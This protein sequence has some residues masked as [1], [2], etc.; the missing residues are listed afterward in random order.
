MCRMS[1]LPI[2]KMGN[3]VVLMILI[4]FAVLPYT[5][6]TFLHKLATND[7]FL[8]EA[9]PYGVDD[10][11][12]STS[13]YAS[14]LTKSCVRNFP[15]IYKLEISYEECWQRSHFLPVETSASRESEYSTTF[16][17]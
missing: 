13:N 4:C 10:V 11:F 16:F 2:G 12:R 17:T 6:Q 5:F 14:F 3:L 1:F 9:K 8:V 15:G 7:K